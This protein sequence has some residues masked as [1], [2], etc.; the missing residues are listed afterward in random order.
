MDLSVS[1]QAQ[2]PFS[3][4]DMT[5]TGLVDFLN[6]IAPAGAYT[7]SEL[8]R[9]L[10]SRLVASLG[11]DIQIEVA[12]FKASKNEAPPRPAPKSAS[13]TTQKSQK[14]TPKARALEARKQVLLYLNQ[15]GAS[16]KSKVVQH[17]SKKAQADWNGVFNKMKKEGVLRK[18]G[19]SGPRV[20]WTL[21]PK[22]RAA[23]KSLKK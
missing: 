13:P 22:G 15:V 14:L 3:G 10:N 16:P 9:V 11:D 17:V 20:R 21:T 12:K 18:K 1:R 6:Q 19:T 23:I 8:R 7:V 4:G 2:H 5:V